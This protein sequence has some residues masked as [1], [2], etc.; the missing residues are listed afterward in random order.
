[1]GFL[2]LADDRRQPGESGAAMSDARRH[3]AL[4][5][6]SLHPWRWE[7]L[8]PYDIARAQEA[9]DSRRLAARMRSFGFSWK[10]VGHRLSVSAQR[11]RQIGIS[12]RDRRHSPIDRYCVEND[13]RDLAR[14]FERERKWESTRAL[15]IIARLYRQGYL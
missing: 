1:M 15:T 12:W 4:R 8:L 13:M 5:R 11:A 10:E 14:A 9:E 7:D 2:D 6:A 3:P